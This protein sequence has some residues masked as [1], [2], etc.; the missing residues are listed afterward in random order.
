MSSRVAKKKE[1]LM[2]RGGEGLLL[3]GKK[4]R[5][6]TVGKPTGEGS[7]IT[8]SISQEC[9]KQ[10]AHTGMGATLPVVRS[11]DQ[12]GK[13]SSLQ[14]QTKRPWGGGWKNKKKEKKGGGK[15]GSRELD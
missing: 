11:Q 15:G 6:E 3:G 9:G 7:V 1:N 10:G 2:T 4:G 14:I 8:T 13:G 12:S 5:G